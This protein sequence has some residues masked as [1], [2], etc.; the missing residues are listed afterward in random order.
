[1]PRRGPAATSAR[2]PSPPGGT[3][4]SPVP[5]GP[6][7][8]PGRRPPPG[9][10]RPPPPGPGTQAPRPGSTAA[11]RFG[12][13]PPGG[14]PSRA[15][16][17]PPRTASVRSASRP[18]APGPPGRSG[19]AG[20]PW[21]R[22]TPRARSFPGAGPSPRTSGRDGPRSGGRSSPCPEP[23]PHGP[24]RGSSPPRPPGC[25]PVPVSGPPCRRPRTPRSGR[26]T[27]PSPG[28]GSSPNRNR[29]RIH[30]TNR[31]R[32]DKGSPNASSA[33]PFPPGPA[34]PGNS[35]QTS[36]RNPIRRPVRWASS[37]C[38]RSPRSGRM[39]FVVEIRP[40]RPRDH[41]PGRVEPS[42]GPM[43][44]PGPGRRDAGHR[45]P[46][47]IRCPRGR[48]DPRPGL[49]RRRGGRPGGRGPPGAPI[50][51]PHLGDPGDPRR[52]RGVGGAAV[53]RRTPAA[54]GAP[55]VH[56]RRRGDL[57]PG[58]GGGRSVNRFR[59]RDTPRVRVVL[60]RG[61]AAVPPARPLH[62]VPGRAARRRNPEP[63]RWHVD[64]RTESGLL[65][66]RV[67]FR[68]R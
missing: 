21:P 3:P 25:H 20:P 26:R 30:T 53:D 49:D 33:T 51:D 46:G 36:D 58:S 52:R 27:A 18:V 54:P 5:P 66:G 67:R 42:L 22:P 16:S 39:R 50:P 2:R 60:G 14:G 11:R 59:T 57:H 4:G 8:A 40:G 62:V 24:A 12:P 47:G 19:P 65:V 35:T 10:R 48:F 45:A 68:V 28:Q 17:G 61:S 31:R 6:T 34:G 38:P 55:D 41:P 15:A 7:G 37:R 63:G 64:L 44:I 56:G 13:R 32:Q 9:P 23:A 43:G 29:N 1:M